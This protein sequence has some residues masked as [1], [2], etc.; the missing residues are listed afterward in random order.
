MKNQA[1]TSR[2]SH[3]DLVA[4]DTLLKAL[5]R[6]MP[7]LVALAPKERRRRE[8]RIRKLA[9]AEHAL[10]GV[11]ENRAVLPP[12]FDFEQFEHDVRMTRGLYNALLDLKQ[13]VFDLQ[14]TLAISGSEVAK[15]CDA[16]C[17]HLKA[18][19]KMTPGLRAITQ[20]LAAVRDPS[21]TVRLPVSTDFEHRPSAAPAGLPGNG[22]IASA[23]DAAAAGLHFP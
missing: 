15:G 16:V 2:I 8:L 4:V 19:A 12:Y 10:E 20:Q 18:A 9:L 21:S 22:G 13:L 1:L 23:S 17:G 11:R 14:A 6:A 7:F 3:Q 5:R